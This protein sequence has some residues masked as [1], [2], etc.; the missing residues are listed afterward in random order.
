MRIE[1]LRAYIR[2][3]LREDLDARIPTQLISTSDG[4]A[5]EDKKEEDFVKEFSST[6][7]IAGFTLP[8]GMKP[9]R[10]NKA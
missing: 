2:C 7:G 4:E 3:F 6:G 9:D 5:E 8:L 1:T 10:K